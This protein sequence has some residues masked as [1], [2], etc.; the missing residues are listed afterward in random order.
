MKILILLAISLLFISS[1][2]QRAE[3][4]D[5]LNSAIRSSVAGMRAQSER[6]K[7]I[8][9]NIANSQVTGTHPRMDPYRRKQV[10]FTNRLDEELGAEVV[11]LGSIMLDK[12]DFILKYEPNHPAADEKGYVKYPNVNPVL[13]SID[14]K[15]ADRSFNGN[16]SALE[17]SKANQ[18]KIIDLMR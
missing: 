11:K 10:T 15:E 3:A 12:S 13:E 4:Y 18:A 9:E 17:I 14:L 1:L 2:K 16:L 5:A 6:I 7:V 8:A